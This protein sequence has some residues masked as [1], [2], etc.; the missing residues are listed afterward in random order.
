WQ[1]EKCLGQVHSSFYS[2]S[3]PE[4]ETSPDTQ[5]ESPVGASNTKGQM[6]WADSSLQASKQGAASDDHLEVPPS[7]H[8]S[9][10][11][12]AEDVQRA[13]LDP[14]APD[15]GGQSQNFPA[16]MDFQG[17]F[18][19]SIRSTSQ[20]VLKMVKTPPFHK[21]SEVDGT[22]PENDVIGNKIMQKLSDA[23]AKRRNLISLDTFS[24]MDS[25]NAEH[26]EFESEVCR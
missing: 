8:P 20:H 9:E 19:E 18:M 1:Q 4:P 23:L 17:S 26:V 2:E 10:L 12:E 3:N 21:P 16:P 25:T 15:G 22:Q 7:S 24:S 11:T 14:V 5:I 13:P 6:L